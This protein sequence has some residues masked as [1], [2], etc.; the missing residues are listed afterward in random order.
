MNL[1]NVARRLGVENP[2]DLADLKGYLEKTFTPEEIQHA[3]EAFLEDRLP[4]S[5]ANAYGKMLQDIP[6]PMSPEA[7]SETIRTF[8]NERD[9]AMEAWMVSSGI[10]L[11]PG[12][13][14]ERARSLLRRHFTGERISEK[15]LARPIKGLPSEDRAFDFWK[16]SSVDWD[17]PLPPVTSDKSPISDL[18]RNAG[19]AIMEHFLL[20]AFD[21]MKEEAPVAMGDIP[22][23]YTEAVYNTISTFEP[24]VVAFKD[25]GR[26]KAQVETSVT[27]VFSEAAADEKRQHGDMSIDP[28][29]DQERAVSAPPEIPENISAYADV[30]ASQIYPGFK[31]M[32]PDQLATI[33]K[34]APHYG[35]AHGRS[36]TQAPIDEYAR[37][38]LS[39]EGDE[40]SADWEAT[41]RGTE[42]TTGLT[43]GQAH[44]LLREQQRG[45]IVRWKEI[46]EHRQPLFQ[47]KRKGGIEDELRAFEKAL[48][49][50]PRAEL[51]IES[52]FSYLGDSRKL[53]NENRE[54][55]ETY[56]EFPGFVDSKRRGN[57][58]LLTR[59]HRMMLEF[60]KNAVEA[61]IPL[62]RKSL[63][64][65]AKGWDE[66]GAE[67]ADILRTIGEDMS[68]REY[69]PDEA[70]F[71]LSALSARTQRVKERTGWLNAKPVERN[72]PSLFQY[73]AGREE[74][75]E[76][77]A[78][79]KS[80][81]AE[82]AT[83]TTGIDTELLGDNIY[84]VAD[85]QDLEGVS[86][87]RQINLD[88]KKAAP[89]SAFRTGSDMGLEDSSRDDFISTISGL[90][91]SRVVEAPTGSA[92]LGEMPQ[93]REGY[94]P[95]SKRE[96]ATTI[97]EMYELYQR[98]QSGELVNE[99]PYRQAFEDYARQ[100]GNVDTDVMDQLFG[101]SKTLGF[102]EFVDI[103]NG[104]QTPSPP[105]RTSVRAPRRKRNHRLFISGEGNMAQAAADR[106]VERG[107]D[108]VVPEDDPAGLRDYLGDRTNV[109]TGG[110]VDAD[111][112]FFI[113]DTEG[114][115]V[116]KS[117]GKRVHLHDGKAH[118]AHNTDV[119][120]E[121]PGLSLRRT[122]TWRTEVNVNSA[123]RGELEEIPGVGPSLA[124][125]IVEEREKGAF[126]D[127]DDL[128][129]RVPGIGEKKAVSMADSVRFKA[130]EEPARQTSNKTPRRVTPEERA[131]PFLPDYD[132][133]P[134]VWADDFPPTQA[135]DFPP[136][137]TD[138]PVKEASPVNR[139]A[140]P[141][142]DKEPRRVSEPPSEVFQRQEESSSP[143]EEPPPRWGP[144]ELP[145]DD[146]VPP[147]FFY[148]DE[149]EENEPEEPDVRP[150]VKTPKR[151][152]QFFE[153]WEA[154]REGK[155]LPRHKY[156]D[157]SDE[158]FEHVQEWQAK[159]QAQFLEEARSGVVH[160]TA[161]PGVSEELRSE[162]YQNLLR[163]RARSHRE[164]T[165]FEQRHDPVS[166]LNNAA[167]RA[168]PFA[169]GGLPAE[170]S[171]DEAEGA[172][173]LINTALAKSTEAGFEG[174]GS[175]ENF[176][177]TSL[178]RAKKYITDTINEQIDKLP[179]DDVEGRQQL[180]RVRNL[181]NDLLKNAYENAASE[182]EANGEEAGYWSANQ[183]LYQ[184]RYN[185]YHDGPE[186]LEALYGSD[187]YIKREVD[188]R[189]G[190]KKVMRDGAVI[191]PD[192]D[193]EG[194]LSVAIEPMGEGSMF[195]G[196]N[197]PYAA[198]RAWYA[199]R[200]IKGLLGATFGAAA[201]EMD[202]F[203]EYESS[204]SRLSGGRRGNVEMIQQRESEFQL[205]MGKAAYQQFGFMRSIPADLL[206]SDTAARVLQG[207]K[208]ALGLAMIG[209]MVNSVLEMG[210]VGAMPKLNNIGIYAGATM[211]GL[212]I[213][214][215]VSN[216]VLGRD[217]SL[218]DHWN[219]YKK[220]VFV[221]GRG[222]LSITDKVLGTNLN[223][224][225]LSDWE[226]NYIAS[227]TDYTD[228]GR[229]E[230]LDERL[231]DLAF[232]YSVDRSELA[233]TATRM[234]QLIGLP[235][236][237]SGEDPLAA[238]A[239]D[240][241]TTNSMTGDEAL[242]QAWAMAQEY[243]A[244]PQGQ[245]WAMGEFF[246]RT[247]EENTR[248]Q[249]WAAATKGFRGA[250][251]TEAGL[252]ESGWYDVQNL[253]IDLADPT[254][255]RA[256]PG[257]TT[258]QGVS[259][260]YGLGISA[261]QTWK[262]ALS[263]PDAASSEYA[264][265]IMGTL[266]Q[267]GYENIPDY[268]DS[269][270]SQ[271]FSGYEYGSIAQLTQ[272]LA[273]SNYDASL[274]QSNYA[275]FAGYSQAQRANVLSA[276]QTTSQLG[277][278]ADW[279]AISGS[280]D[281]APDQFSAMVNA[282]TSQYSGGGLREYIGIGKDLAWLFDGLHGEDLRS[283]S[284]LLQS[285]IDRGRD[286]DYGDVR[287][288]A[289]DLNESQT[290]RLIG[291]LDTAKE[292]GFEETDG[293]RSSLADSARL[294]PERN[295]GA[296]M[297]LV[298]SYGT[299]GLTDQEDIDRALALSGFS[300][301]TYTDTNPMIA[302]AVSG[303]TDAMWQ[304]G[305]T[306]SNAQSLG[307]MF[308][309]TYFDPLEQNR[310]QNLAGIAFNRGANAESSWAFGAGLS[311]LSQWDTTQVTSALSG[312]KLALSRLLTQG[313]GG[314]FG[315]FLRG[316]MTYPPESYFTE[317]G[318]VDLTAL[319]STGLMPLIDPE[320]GLDA[321]RVEQWNLE[322]D[323]HALQLG[324]KQ[325]RMGRS[326]SQFAQSE[327]F[328]TG[329]SFVNPFTEQS[330]FV[331][332]GQQQI[333]DAMFNIGVEQQRYNLD[334]Q[335]ETFKINTR[336]QRESLDTGQEQM[337]T[338]YQWKVQDWEYGENVNELQYAWQ[339]EDFDTN[340]R[341]ARGRQRYQLMRQRDRAT[342]M[343][344]MRSGHSDDQR[345]RIDQEQE[346]AR[347]AHEKQREYFEDNF[348]LQR[349]RLGHERRF[350]EE[351]LTW[352]QRERENA[353]RQAELSAQYQRDSLAHQS[354]MIA[355]EEELYQKQKDLNTEREAAMGAWET[356]LSEDMVGW[357]DSLGERVSG[358]T[359][360]GG[361]SSW[362]DSA[363]GF[364]GGDSGSDTLSGVLSVLKSI[365]SKT[366]G[367]AGS[368]FDLYSSMYQEF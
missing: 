325:W 228:R 342:I 116:A 58:R 210:Q 104:P 10:S 30:P 77:K 315:D 172:F 229:Y 81:L 182:L 24:G 177:A 82:T 96:S 36:R 101:S 282:I 52:E 281:L 13:G 284:M 361:I 268:M 191:P 288:W 363:A 72:A 135:D 260:Q 367:S 60:Q 214:N 279:N 89:V 336:R 330:E 289:I 248:K 111:E 206:G 305:L 323:A 290:K 226:K 39:Q 314:A 152:D 194:S 63:E 267:Q 225:S 70:K 295:F 1:R 178:L 71:H 266:A 234:S 273:Q 316:N 250:I 142:P 185:K 245:A 45:R 207:G 28:H 313:G 233:G 186:R 311:G 105:K 272:G 198:I 292:Y 308:G 125:A 139:H 235:L 148:N 293:L 364:L 333:S 299:M 231:G 205:E 15:A 161:P 163:G 17:N 319:K 365:D 318:N 154:A 157:V 274:F 16:A 264:A 199:T 317:Y 27:R 12:K 246:G 278:P 67:F 249:A 143:S 201:Q 23:L 255:A 43:V 223:K 283:A 68:S 202:Q 150:K 259:A 241:A 287:G 357:I 153:L 236:S 256:L 40:Y 124:A 254:H 309:E 128:A 83:S 300:S 294:M 37:E 262:W 138:T 11:P 208:A 99:E 6:G 341:Y 331:Q 131:R 2:E 296:A 162:S 169:Q 351:R 93:S 64:R 46:P 339:M 215:E 240:Y 298:E 340:I 155:Q 224:D 195:G 121:D 33:D 4:M 50:G 26:L 346:W 38:W 219:T 358:I 95:E 297:S 261:L 220:G 164:T 175:G 359:L 59:H 216:A 326:Q 183:S 91:P 41:S 42:I 328:R 344:S 190:L 100:K 353:R 348:R 212:T 345:E 306:P 176:L 147:E 165:T 113:D 62:D 209:P 218:T 47:G 158:D 141:P 221:L 118:T 335:E 362:L 222:A 108:V 192:P 239:Q 156:P 179:K 301:G 320:T 127:I 73:R 355:K 302:S 343:E 102:H 112:G 360:L 307:A 31:N 87:N 146:D 145:S 276:I 168:D 338:R 49:G 322:S 277:L 134:R 57:R 22:G 130:P 5:E 61:G 211:A 257:A 237:L 94:F 97:E 350:F 21:R 151:N 114:F 122:R 203:A 310:I 51:D 53:E 159:Q 48:G 269:L 368:V 187:E 321:W 29:L 247:P 133:S 107:W 258:M 174:V 76:H 227:A 69:T 126:Q 110:M 74:W 117:S 66:R 167:R 327:A 173:R 334:Y 79:W 217:D 80:F 55:L 242:N 3:Q 265:G 253:D 232:R 25:A 166:L 86:E 270:T 329:G 14:R 85:D 137:Q 90:S 213:G 115:E 188:K 230:Q 98:Y 19:R 181:A 170:V 304:M 56:L 8:A 120:R 332:F 92:E 34:I 286:P 88:D 109:H 312:D 251:S 197:N 7:L 252:L 356:F 54:G 352:Q 132:D 275:E 119:D 337:E 349:E 244:S 20:H 144:G 149:F 18:G 180:Q 291:G 123:S 171:P 189:G 285:E 35:F 106:A 129:S 303:Y 140:A 84:L 44:T 193:K 263:M 204:V 243:S 160:E 280:R 184:D 78:A 366:K 65:Y 354:E 32:T 196:R 103:L 9:R 271:G 238:I 324:D 347:E 200:A 136:A 75:G